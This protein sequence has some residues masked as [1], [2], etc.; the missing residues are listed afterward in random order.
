MVKGLVVWVV[1]LTGL[2]VGCSNESDI[3]RDSDIKRESSVTDGNANLVYSKKSDVDASTSAVPRAVDRKLI[4]NADLNIEVAD[5]EPAR[6]QVEKLV[7]TAEGYV[8]SFSDR[9]N[10]DLR[11][12]DFQVKVPAGQLQSFI[13]DIEKME[14]ISFERSIRAEDVGEEYVDLQA[15]LKVKQAVEARMIQLMEKA[16]SS[17][18][19]IAF[20]VQLGEIQEEIET[21]KGRIQYIDRNVAF[22][23]VNISLFERLYGAPANG[24]SYS[25]K[26]WYE[27]KAGLYG[28]GHFFANGLLVLMAILPTFILL[29]GI[30]LLAW[31]LRRRRRNKKNEE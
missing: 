17:A 13:A 1:L 18:D 16:T 27:L 12:G 19:L 9:T 2:L 10:S 21:L 28:I 3:A 4:Y 30:A 5:L 23:T 22:S 15:R 24:A 6:K 25:A 29:T 14:L 8:L 26:L 11:G 31:W 7:Q 20:A